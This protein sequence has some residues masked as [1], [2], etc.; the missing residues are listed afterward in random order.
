MP[1]VLRNIDVYKLIWKAPA[2]RPLMNAEDESTF[3]AY[4]DRTREGM[5]R[6]PIAAQ[7][8]DARALFRTLAS[9]GSPGLVGPLQELD[10][11]LYYQPT[12]PGD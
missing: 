2:L 8:A 3:K 12:P 4:R 1:V 5:L 9:V 6:R 10:L 11:G 7:E